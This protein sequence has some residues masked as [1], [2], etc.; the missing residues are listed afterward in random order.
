MPWISEELEEWEELSDEDR[1]AIRAL[2]EDLGVDL[3]DDDD[4]D[5]YE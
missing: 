5:Y 2:L 3:P 4:D 1:E